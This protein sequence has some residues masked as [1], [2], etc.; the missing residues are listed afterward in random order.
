[1]SLQR[2][3]AAR[4]LKCG[5]NKV[6]IDPSRLADVKDAI[7]GADIQKLIK[8]KVIKK[9][10]KKGV[11]RARA[12]KIRAQKSKGRRKG[13]GSRRGKRTARKSKKE[14]WMR[15]IRAL[16]KYLAELKGKNMI[17]LTTYREMYRKCSGGFFRNKSHLK[18]YL[19]Q[20]KLL[21][22][23]VKNERAKKKD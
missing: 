7:T 8:D 18:L 2:K 5:V 20:H 12:K 11:S 3:I 22:Q 16:R 13:V 15:R 21:K 17:S 10:K 23:D 19:T 14:K 4:K 9:I 6:W 1:M